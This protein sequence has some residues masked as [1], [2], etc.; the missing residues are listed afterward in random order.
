[1]LVAARLVTS[2]DGVYE[3]A[4]EALARAWPRL[5]GWLDDDV[6]G[7]RL[8]HHLT[9]AADAW[10][11]LGGPDSEL[12]R[13]ARLQRVLDWLERTDPDLTAVERA[14]LDASQQHAQDEARS[15]AEQARQQSRMIRRLRLVLTG[16]CVLLG[17]ALTAGGLAVHQRNVA[18]ESSAAALASETAAVARQAGANALL[19]ADID[20]SI[21]LAIAAVRLDDSPETRS[22]L[23]AAIGK[24]PELVR[25]TPLSGDEAVD[26]LDVTRDGRHV[27]ALDQRH[28]LWLYEAETGRLLADS[29]VGP[30]R[31]DAADSDRRLAVSPNGGIVAVATTTLVGPPL[32]LLDAPTLRAL[33]SLGGLPARGWMAADLAYSGTGRYLAALLRRVQPQR[34]GDGSPVVGWGGVQMQAT[35]AVALVWDLTSPQRPIRVPLTDADTESLALDQGGEV[36]YTSGPLTRGHDLVTASNRECFPSMHLTSSSVP[37]DRRSQVSEHQVPASRR[38]LGST[39]E[40]ARLDRGGSTTPILE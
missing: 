24:R 33:P 35:A 5:R 20:S 22:S 38:W 32:R 6:E 31:V 21:L 34:T 30:V 10:D 37:T 4:H 11:Q 2:D 14:F 9:G 25:S 12:Y 23:L 19:T 8:L 18:D 26:E 16:A 36:L 1:M 27:V 17:I 28:H 29:Q 13:G 15:A 39:G 3:I 40:A 7:R